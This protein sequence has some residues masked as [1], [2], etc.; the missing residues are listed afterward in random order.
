M[1]NRER[2]EKV[3]L[4]LL[5]LELLMEV[6]ENRNGGGTYSHI[7][8]REVLK[9]YNYLSQQEKSFIKRLF[10]G[11]LERMITLDFVINQY[12]KVKTDKLKPQ[13]RAILRMSVYQILYMDAVPDSA[14]CNEAVKLAQKKGFATLKGFVNGVLRNIAKNKDKL[15]Y[16][17]LSVEYSMPEWIVNLWTSQLGEEKTHAV[18]EGL[19]ME[20][21]VTVRLRD[22]S[23]KEALQKALAVRGGRMTAH[24]YFEDAYQIEKTDD[25]TTLPLY[26]EGAFV[27]QDVSSMLA[28]RALLADEFLAAKRALGETLRIVDVCAAPGGKSM[29]AADLLRD[30]GVCRGDF[31]IEARDI[32]EQKVALMQ[33][34]FVR[35]SLN[36]DSVLAVVCDALTRDEQQTADIV[37]A[38]VPCSG[39]GVIG[40]KRDIKYRVKQEQ[41]AELVTL[42]RRILEK[43]VKMLKP[44]GRLLF[45]TCTINRA[46]NEENFG[47]LVK[48]K[49]MTPVSFFDALPE[50]LRTEDVETV[51]TAKQGY[52]QLLPKLHNLDGF[53]ISVL[54]K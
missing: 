35:C 47:W 33:E 43:A 42:Q 25:M 52:L 50:G 40:K 10:E 7:A 44:D 2:M 49:K 3:N 41:L 36:R 38:D 24:P 48:E 28:V 39:F 29:L 54:K 20:H 5:V 22:K 30:M 13:I 21:P 19:L 4:R 26:Q 14:A 12:S 45:S 37:I 18:L 53:F 34:N 9:K 1:E 8:V 27:V 6:T 17:D 51:E 32:S 31:Q 16:P 11:T 23:V 46:E 15:V